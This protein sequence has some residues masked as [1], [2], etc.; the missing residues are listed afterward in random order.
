MSTTDHCTAG[1]IRSIE[2]SN[3]V[4]QEISNGI[5]LWL[6]VGLSNPVKYVCPL[7]KAIRIAYMGI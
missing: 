5:T 6:Q 4:V 1:R 3:D 7:R 2:G